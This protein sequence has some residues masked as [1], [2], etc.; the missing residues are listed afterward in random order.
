M[1]FIVFSTEGRILMSLTEDRWVQIPLKTSFNPSLLHH[2]A[3]RN[4]CNTRFGHAVII[5]QTFYDWEDIPNG[6]FPSLRLVYSVV[7][8]DKC[9]IMQFLTH[10]GQ[11][12]YLIFPQL[13][14]SAATKS[15]HCFSASLGY[16]ILRRAH[17]L[18]I[19]VTVS[20]AS[21][22]QYCFSSFICNTLL[23]FF[24]KYRA[25][26]NYYSITTPHCVWR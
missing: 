12:A 3:E 11:L 14:F 9:F 6:R 2:P 8:L 16:L 1:S 18:S 21:T 13:S 5:L 19:C 17:F 23:I 25:H 15:F 4:E 26:G 20:Q 22:L 24:C 7:Y 10:C